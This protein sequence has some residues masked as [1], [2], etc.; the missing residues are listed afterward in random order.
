MRGSWGAITERP[1]DLAPLK[2]RQMVPARR[3]ARNQ[4]DRLLF[5]G[6]CIRGRK[7]NKRGNDLAYFVTASQFI[8]NQGETCNESGN[9]GQAVF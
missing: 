5:S 2:L 9:T 3:H 7:Q 4:L 1:Q 6:R 8:L